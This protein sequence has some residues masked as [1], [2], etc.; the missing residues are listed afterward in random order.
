VHLDYGTKIFLSE[1]K[2]PLGYAVISL[3]S[4][5]KHWLKCNTGKSVILFNS[6]F[7]RYGSLN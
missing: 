3:Y 4:T 5:V 7:N 2:L 6:F 1:S